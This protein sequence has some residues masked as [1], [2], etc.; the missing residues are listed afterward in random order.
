M[1]QPGWKIGHIKAKTTGFPGTAGRQKHLQD[2]RVR[3][4]LIAHRNAHRERNAGLQKG[5]QRVRRRNA[6]PVL[7]FKRLPVIRHGH[8]SILRAIGCLAWSALLIGSPRRLRFGF[9]ETDSAPNW[10]INTIGRGINWL[11]GEAP[12]SGLLRTGC[13]RHYVSSARVGTMSAKS[14][15]TLPAAG[16]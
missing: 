11:K 12:G 8:L 13:A 2:T 5:H 3:A 4:V 7:W 1:Q 15:P 14:T 16:A 9:A 6:Q 10:P